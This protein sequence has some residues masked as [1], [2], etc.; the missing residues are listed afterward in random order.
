ML[1]GRLRCGIMRCHGGAVKQRG[2]LIAA[3]GAAATGSTAPRDLG[4]ARHSVG[5]QLANRT[6]GDP[7]TL[8]DDHLRASLSACTSFIL[9][10]KVII[11]SNKRQLQQ[12]ADEV[13]VLD[14]ELD[15]HPIRT[16]GKPDARPEAIF[17][18]VIERTADDRK[19]VMLLVIQ[20][21]DV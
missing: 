7:D 18:A 3:R 1:R 4:D 5:D 21:L 14:V 9:K 12:R 15:Q 17:E 13:L 20:R 10:L 6:V 8:T 19:D 2:D 16:G 11:N